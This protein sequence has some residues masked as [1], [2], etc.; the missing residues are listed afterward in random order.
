M[1]ENSSPFQMVVR[2]RPP[3]PPITPGHSNI[4]F[5]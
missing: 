1:L 4:K 2:I 3:R 5:E